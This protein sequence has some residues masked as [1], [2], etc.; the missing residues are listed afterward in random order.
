[1]SL[2]TSLWLVAHPVK[3]K[4]AVNLLHSGVKELNKN[5]SLCENECFTNK[6]DVGISTSI[7]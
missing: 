6:D 2:T 3:I 7:P 1:M 4:E 5:I